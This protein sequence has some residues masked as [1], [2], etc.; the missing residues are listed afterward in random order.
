MGRVGLGASVSLGEDEAART[1]AGEEEV[2]GLLLLLHGM[3]SSCENLGHSIDIG[4]DT[5]ID[6]DIDIDR[7]IV[8]IVVIRVLSHRLSLLLLFSF[9]SP[10]LFLFSSLHSPKASPT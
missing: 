3:T 2:E 4:I 5:D 10:F 1:A 6:M 8:A 9:F 7:D